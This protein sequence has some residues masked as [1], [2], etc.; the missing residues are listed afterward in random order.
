[1]SSVNP[2]FVE[3]Y[4]LEYQ[5][6]PK[7]K[8]FAPLA[9][10][11]RKMG[12]V[13]EALQICKRGVALHPDFASGRVALAKVLLEKKLHSEAL[14]QL[15]RAA[16]LSPD[17]LLAHALMGEALIE[18][19]RPKEA[20]K[21]YKMVLFLNPDDERARATV[22][23]W[24]FLTAEEYDDEA[25][26]MK[27]LFRPETQKLLPPLPGQNAEDDA[28][29]LAPGSAEKEGR[30]KAETEALR[31]IERALSLAD[32]FTIR[33]DV[34]S[35]IELLESARDQ[36]GSHPELDKRLNLLSRRVQRAQASQTT[37]ASHADP[38]TDRRIDGR[39]Q[40]LELFLRRIN[41]RRYPNS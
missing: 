2:E 5:K 30:S 36:F 39:R 33:N 29:A 21:A 31:E 17:N 41:E 28:T 37:S 34:D 23:K 27:P 19:R 10:A 4:Q 26:A 16:E 1:M 6:N 18:L 3:R 8:V 9:E 40:K 15:K 25:F 7:S 35:A 20:L 12:L 32:A 13:E 11:Y 22:R 14:E 38:G 24:E